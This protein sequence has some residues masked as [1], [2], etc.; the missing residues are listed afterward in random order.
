MRFSIRGAVFLA[1]ACLL[2]AVTG[3]AQ[4]SPSAP[5]QSN[6]STDLGITYDAERAKLA[7]SNCGC[8][9]LQGGGVDGAVTFW[10]GF[11]IAATFTGDHAS[12]VTPGVDIN[13]ISFMAGP[14]YTYTSWDTSGEKPRFQ[15]YGQ[16][17]FGGVHAFDGVFP[18][19][20]GTVPTADSLAIQAGG[21]F[22]I[23]LTR[24]I[25]VRVAE[26]SYVRTRLPNNGND[27]Q[28]DLRLGAGL[29]YHFGANTPPPP[30][31]LACSANPSSI[32]PGD[33][34]AVTATV[35]NVEPKFNAVYSWSGVP[36]LKG[37][38]TS[39][40][41]D[42]GSTGSLSA[43]A[44]TVKV[45]VKEGKPG[46]E[47]LKPGQTADCSATFTV[48]AYEPPTVSC[49]A[50]PSTIKPG[51]KSTITASAVSPQNRPLTYNYSAV[52]G[53][54]SGTGASATFD[55]TGSPTGA[56]AITCNVSDDKGQS[57]TSGTTVTITAPYV[58][59]APRTQ[60][61][62][63]ISFE[64]DPK[65]P[66]RVDNEAKA[67]LDQVA[68][69]LVSHADAKVVVVGEATA[70]ERTPKKGRHAKA[71]DFAALRAV[72]AKEYLVTD[73]G[74]DAS[75]I[76]VTTGS[77]DGQTAEDYLVPAGATFTND[78]QG[79]TPVDETA[80]K[81]ETRK[82]LSERH[83]HHKKATVAPAP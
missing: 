42:S 19:T 5:K 17:L 39:A 81:P 54:I 67:C 75:R 77:T 47:G 32:F 74:I 69:D 53:A 83:P 16:G 13:K 63:S 43:G 1:G 68:L 15:I 80:V 24:H 30:V 18:A 79:T 56:V 57:A 34:I 76:S 55:S 3:W 49:S 14:R 58:P 31:T 37:A 29:V 62:C 72:N 7:P 20:G 21:G 33:P 73:K 52:S 36:G 48:K 50:S 22:N 41:L 59:P 8:F 4:H 10:K 2:T 82:P 38:G 28:N 9:W 12:N 66:T 35:G 46:K 70:A 26:A 44:Y 25:G 78:V 27:T 61:L 6:V 11:G 60:A 64:K 51:D 40:S 45:E 23:Y 71:E 65:R